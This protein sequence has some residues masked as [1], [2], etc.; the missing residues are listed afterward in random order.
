MRHGLICV[1]CTNKICWQTAKKNTRLRL[2]REMFTAATMTKCLEHL[3]TLLER[4]ASL[5]TA[6][7]PPDLVFGRSRM[8]E[9]CGSLAGWC[10]E[11]SLPDDDEDDGW[12]EHIVQACIATF[13]GHFKIT[14]RKKELVSACCDDEAVDLWCTAS[15]AG[16][17]GETV[18]FAARIWMVITSEMCLEPK[19]K[20][21]VP[22][23]ATHFELSWVPD[24]NLVAHGL[25]VRRLVPHGF[26]ECFKGIQGTI[27][28]EF[29]PKK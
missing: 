13:P 24:S 14:F 21:L 17:C 3:G 26:E 23:A 29:R 10:S 16:R 2:L 27:D 15:H 6:T 5:H 25:D 7:L 11:D 18:L 28:L 4:L 22:G 20:Y 8:F 1:T 12:P 9:M 19:A